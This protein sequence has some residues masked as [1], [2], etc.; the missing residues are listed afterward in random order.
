M[1]ES[2][3]MDIPWLI[4]VVAKWSLSSAVILAV[5][6]H[7]YEMAKW[8][9]AAARLGHAVTNSR[10][11]SRHPSLVILLATLLISPER[12]RSDTEGSGVSNEAKRLIDL[13]RRLP[14]VMW[15][16][17]AIIIGGFLSMISLMILAALLHAGE[18]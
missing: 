6:L 3:S 7:L 18:G 16:A 15:R 12:F 17:C 4:F 9:S 5:L 2:G 10:A 1:E 11:L 8:L 14:M 13:R